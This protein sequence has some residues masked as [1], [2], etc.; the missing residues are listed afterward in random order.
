MEASTLKARVPSG[1]FQEVQTLNLII[2]PSPISH[3]WSE[4]GLIQLSY[5]WFQLG[6]F[7]PY[8]IFIWDS[9]WTYILILTGYCPIPFNWVWW[10]CGGTAGDTNKMNL[11]IMKFPDKDFPSSIILLCRELYTKYGRSNP[12]DSGKQCLSKVG[13]QI[14]LLVFMIRNN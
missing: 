14:I 1:V 6:F 2:V 9:L 8:T 4:A 7:F 5:K 13:K 12:S 11:E 10:E 3:P